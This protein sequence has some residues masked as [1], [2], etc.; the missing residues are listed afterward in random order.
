MSEFSEP[1]E[2]DVKKYFSDEQWNSIEEYEKGMFLNQ[3]RN[4]EVMKSLGKYR[5]YISFLYDL[6]SN[7]MRYYYM[8]MYKYA[9]FYWLKY[10]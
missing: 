9:Q 3:L 6:K 8:E 5:I 7:Y 1:T 2:L 4:Y 10:N